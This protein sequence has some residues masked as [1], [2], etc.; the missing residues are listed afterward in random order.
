MS[1]SISIFSVQVPEVSQNKD[2]IFK[3]FVLSILI[4]VPKLYSMGGYN[5]MPLYSGITLLILV[6][7]NRLSPARLNK[8]LIKTSLIALAFVFLNRFSTDSIFLL[9][10]VFIICFI[11][12]R[13]KS[14]FRLIKII[15]ANLVIFVTLFSLIELPFRLSESVEGNP[16]IQ[17]GVRFD[18]KEFIQLRTK[19]YFIR[20]ELASRNSKT[21]MGPNQE[22]Y[23]VSKNLVDLFGQSV[24]LRDFDGSYIKI[25][26]GRR[27][28]IGNTDRRQNRV[29]V[30]GGS[31]IFCAE[32]PDSMTIPSELQKAVLGAG[33][34]V[35]VVNYGIPGIR[36]ESQL[37]TLKTIPD[38]GPSDIVLFYDGVND[39]NTVFR[40]GLESKNA[41]LPGEQ[42]TKFAGFFDKK[43]LLAKTLISGFLDSRGV[44]KIFLSTEA[45]KQVADI[46]LSYDLVARDYV[47]SK[48]AKFVHILQPNWV[49]FKGGVDA[50]KSNK[51]WSDMK[52]IQ[53]YFEKIATPDNKIENFTKGLDGLDATPYIDWAHLDEIGNQKI[54]EEMFKVLKPLLEA[55]KNS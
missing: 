14:N 8:W 10:W 34:L 43:S 49:T 32:V 53:N 46:W 22:Y 15:G 9:I 35:D 55:Q 42:L 21:K 6:A 16:N 54:A 27:V 1:G 20:A 31:T 45:E 41:I 39:L 30:L 28:T 48:G 11:L 13:P 4:A 52:I 19:D 50:T 38:L 5:K 17:L 3:L 37:E 44:D 33:F 36:I 2:R 24:V 40:K 29:F 7:I 26:N 25:K 51:R 18:S 12:L 47:K 23:F